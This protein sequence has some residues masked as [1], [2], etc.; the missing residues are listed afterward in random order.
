MQQSTPSAFTAPT[1]QGFSPLPP[2][3]PP[4]QSLAPRQ[5]SQSRIP[6]GGGGGQSVRTQ[7]GISV[8]DPVIEARRNLAL[9]LGTSDGTSTAQGLIDKLE[10][11]VTQVLDSYEKAFEPGTPRADLASMYTTLDAVISILSRSSLGGYS[12]TSLANPPTISN[13][14]L[15]NATKNVQSLFKEVQRCKEGAEIVRAGLAG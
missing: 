13:S 3:P 5:S 8:Q 14:D 15:E 1:P 12:A 2:P 9:L 10:M 6:T 11:E 7:G 4:T